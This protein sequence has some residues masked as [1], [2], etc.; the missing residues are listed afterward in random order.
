MSSNSLIFSSAM[1]QLQLIYLV[2]FSFQIMYIV[3]FQKFNLSLFLYLQYL[4]FDLLMV[5]SFFLSIF[6]INVLISLSID[7]VIHVIYRYVSIELFFFWLWINF[8]SLFS[9]L[10]I[11][12]LDFRLLNSALLGLRAAVALLLLLLFV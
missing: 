1:S 8:S 5:F 7:S 12:L 9:H 4:P 3:N 6:I 11:F 2:Q 10:V